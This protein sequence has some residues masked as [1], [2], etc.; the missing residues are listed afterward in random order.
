MINK[1]KKYIKYENYDINRI[2]DF[3]HSL[4]NRGRET[5]HRSKHWTK[6]QLLNS[7][8]EDKLNIFLK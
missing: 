1:C 6:W 4:T 3:R 5:K 8:P 2:D 7:I